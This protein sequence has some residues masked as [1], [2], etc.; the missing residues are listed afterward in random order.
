MD[1][2]KLLNLKY[3][4]ELFIAIKNERFELIKDE[5]INTLEYLIFILNV[6]NNNFI[7][8]N[9]IIYI[10]YNFSLYFNKILYI[11]SNSVCTVT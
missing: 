11:T 10:L 8:I 1:E 3:K 6:F 5:Y 7:D 2:I 9:I 4:D